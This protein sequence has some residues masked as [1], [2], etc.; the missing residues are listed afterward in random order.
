MPHLRARIHTR[1]HVTAAADAEVLPAANNREAL[2]AAHTYDRKHHECDA[3]SRNRMQVTKDETVMYSIPHPTR[4]DKI[5]HVS[6]NM[7][8]LRNAPPSPCV[9]ALFTVPRKSRFGLPH[10]ISLPCIKTLA[11]PF[12][13]LGVA[14]L[15]VAVVSGDMSCILRATSCWT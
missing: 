14:L 6:Q 4:V 5:R 8:S 15:V 11:F 12:R 13:S 1:N 9:V 2:S 7:Q 3:F 10:H